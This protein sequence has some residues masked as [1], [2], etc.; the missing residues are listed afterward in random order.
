M[1]KLNKKGD[2]FKALV[3]LDD[4]YTGD[5][6]GRFRVFNEDF[7]GNRRLFDSGKMTKDSPAKEID[8]DVTEVD[9]LMLVFE[10]DKIPA[11]WANARVSA[12]DLE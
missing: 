11:N 5:E 6:T 7:F 9:C 3:G 12:A 2:R 8:L 4:S 1:Y 10:G